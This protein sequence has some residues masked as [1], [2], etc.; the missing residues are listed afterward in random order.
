MLRSG[1]VPIQVFARRVP[2]LRGWHFR[3][4]YAVEPEQPD[5]GRL[6]ELERAE[7]RLEPR[8]GLRER[9][10]ERPEQVQPIAACLSPGAYRNSLFRQHPALGARGKVRP[11]LV[12]PEGRGTRT[13]VIR[14]S[15]PVRGIW[16]LGVFQPHHR[17]P[18]EPRT[19]RPVRNARPVSDDYQHIITRS[20]RPSRWP[21]NSSLP[22]PIR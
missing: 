2:P 5:L 18:V 13:D 12:R 15:S 22:T 10:I 14:A 20:R 4:Q 6:Q 19:E 17:L 21:S 1:I 7:Y 3:S 9:W 16:P 8:R 11:T